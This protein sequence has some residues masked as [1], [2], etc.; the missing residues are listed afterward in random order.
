MTMTRMT[1]N[2]LVLGWALAS[3]ALLL[4]PPIGAVAQ[5]VAGDEDEEVQ[6]ENSFEDFEKLVDGA[7]ITPGFFKTHF[8]NGQ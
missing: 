1:S 2:V 7:E 6:E 3:T 5:D 4:A 8:C